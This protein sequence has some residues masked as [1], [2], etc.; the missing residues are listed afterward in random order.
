MAR[1]NFVLRCIIRKAVIGVTLLGAILLVAVG[2]TGQSEIIEV[3]V[4]REV[5]VTQE[6]LVTVE[7]VKTVEVTREVPVTQEIPVT[8]A[9]PQTVEVTREVETLQTVKVIREVPVTRLVA[10]TPAPA[11]EG[12]PTVAPD[13]PTPV[14]TTTPAPATIPAASATPTPTPTPASQFISWDMEHAHYGEREIFSFRNTALDHPAGRPGPAPTLTYWCDTRA[15]S[16]MYINWH[17]PITAMAS[18]IP[19]SSNDPFSQYRDIPFYALLEYAD[20]I[21]EFIDDLRLSDREQREA[22]EIWDRVTDRW[23]T[24][25]AR[26][27]ALADDPTPGGLVDL[28]SNRTHRSVDIDLDFFDEIINPDQR[29]P[30]GPPSLGTISGVWLVLSDRTQINQGSLGELRATI[31]RAYPPEFPVVGTR[32]VMTAIIRGP[33]QPVVTD[34]KWDIAGIHQVLSHCKAIWQ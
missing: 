17:Y 34:A 18:N 24:G 1:V 26:P 7:A 23:F 20:D 8:V 3:E 13:A 29:S 15:G 14:P 16:A 5:P 4:T 12:V 11:T 32:P 25:K 22:D 19:S 9:V 30:H 31:R 6:V 33:G 10:A 28:L 21:L 27:P 2:C